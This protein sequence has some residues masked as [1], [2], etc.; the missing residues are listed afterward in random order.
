MNKLADFI[1]KTPAPMASQSIMEGLQIVPTFYDPNAVSQHFAALDYTRP[2]INPLA[3][4]QDREML[5]PPSFSMDISYSWDDMATEP[6][7]RTCATSTTEWSGQLQ[8]DP[9]INEIFP[10]LPLGTPITIVFPQIT[11]Y[12]APNGTPTVF[13]PDPI[14]ITWM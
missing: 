1:R 2:S 4:N 9:P 8:S 3:P 11:V 10:Q 5:F 14:E 6:V 12:D 13:T 7:V